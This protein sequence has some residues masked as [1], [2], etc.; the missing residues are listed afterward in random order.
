MHD[1]NWGARYMGKC[2]EIKIYTCGRIK[3]YTVANF[4]WSTRWFIDFRCGF[5]H[6]ISIDVFKAILYMCTFFDK[7]EDLKARKILH[8]FLPIISLLDFHFTSR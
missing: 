1:L 2:I 7:V 3:I 5:M 4:E 6:N 8:K